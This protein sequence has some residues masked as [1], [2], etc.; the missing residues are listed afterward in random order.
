MWNI[1]GIEIFE[2]STIRAHWRIF[3]TGLVL[4]AGT[5]IGPYLLPHWLEFQPPALSEWLVVVGTFIATSLVLYYTMRTR[6][7][8]NRIWELLSP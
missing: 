4:A 7:L 6:A 8:V 2:P 1:L 5:L 3:V